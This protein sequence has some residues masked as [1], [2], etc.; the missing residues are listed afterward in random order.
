M[1]DIVGFDDT[2]QRPIFAAQV[3]YASG[4]ASGQ[5]SLTLLLIG[6]KAA[7]G[8]LVVDSEIRQVTSA[9]DCRTAAGAGSQLARQGIAALKA[10]AKYGGNV[11]ILLAAVTEATGTQ[12][13]V[14]VLLGGTANTAGTYTLTIAG[15][16]INVSISSADALDTIGAN[17]VA[18]VGGTVDCPFTASYNSV[19]KTVTLTCINKGTQG[20]NWIVYQDLSLAPSSL[21]ATITGSS[22]VNT[23]G[24]VT[25]VRAGAA[26]SGT[27]VESY[28]AIIAKLA[29][30]RYAR[31]G[32]GANDATNAA[33][34][35]A[36]DQAKAAVTVQLYEHIVFGINGTQSAATTLAQTDLNDPRHQVVAMRNSETH[37]AELAAGFAA[38]RAAVESADFTSV[39]EGIGPIPD[40]DN[41]PCS[42][43][44]APQ[45]SQFQ[46]SWQPTEENAL[47]NAGVTPIST[48]NGVATVV[49]SITSYCLLSGQQDTRCLDTGDATFPD[50]AALDL[51]QLYAAFR[52]SNRLVQ[53]DNP[54]QIP[55]PK[56]GVA[57]PSLWKSKVKARMAQWRDAGCIPDTFSGTNPTLPVDAVYN[58]AARRIQSNVPFVVNRVQHQLSAIVDQTEPS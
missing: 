19:N 34:L 43:W 56:S 17:I 7:A 4:P 40:Y 49:R 14:T 31:I 55:E 11:K 36:Y 54:P 57:Y 51:A 50:F 37:P 52:A 30:K 28:T 53:D 44:I 24:S 8:N 13:T 33:A 29:G 47:L 15:V 27:G 38:V 16:D 26:A 23:A 58:K 21:T 6:M 10:V 45:R 46:D 3:N 2:Y 42:P 32:S 1:W 25:G 12:A 41:Y 20:L 48:Y 22:T 18:A 39:T 5:G 35:L 9:S